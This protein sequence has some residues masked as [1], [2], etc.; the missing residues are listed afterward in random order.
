MYIYI[1]TYIYIFAV[2]VYLCISESI[3][4]LDPTEE[5]ENRGAESRA[6]VAIFL[7]FRQKLL[8]EIPRVSAFQ[9]KISMDFEA[10][11]GK[12]MGK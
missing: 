7:G 2:S 9:A 12:N 5:L 4:L 3:Y 10:K 8:G 6:W 1:Y 11:I